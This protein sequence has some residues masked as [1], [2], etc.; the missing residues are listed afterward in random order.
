MRVL[1]FF[2]LTICIYS[3]VFTQGNILKGTIL[4]SSKGGAILVLPNATQNIKSENSNTNA[5][6]KSKN[7]LKKVSIPTPIF[8]KVKV[9]STNQ[10]NKKNNTSVNSSTINQ[11]QNSNTQSS[12]TKN[13]IG[14]TSANGNNFN[15]EV[16]TI[17]STSNDVRDA[18]HGRPVT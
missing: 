14:A 11:T 13:W 18:I 6:P 5:N 2:V 17:G 1:I 4:P 9:F 10:F 8:S 16:D 3:Q 15:E 12:L 7:G